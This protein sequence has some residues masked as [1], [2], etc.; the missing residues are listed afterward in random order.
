MAHYRG[1]RPWCELVLGAHMPVAQHGY[2][3]GMSLLFPMERLFENYVACRLRAQL[4]D[5]VLMTQHAATESLCRHMGERMF[6]LQ[7]DILLTGNKTRWVLDAKWKLLDA[8]DRAGKYGLSQ[9]DLYQLHAYGERYLNGS[10]ELFLV[11]PRTPRLQQE[12]PHFDFS[13]T[14]RLRVV[15]FDL[16][17]DRLMACLPFVRPFAALSLAA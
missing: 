8:R 11:Y 16:E 12:L 1:V 6:Q 13:E 17:S 5:N 3:R 9:A 15:P 10:G 4:S 14:L 2:H 7:P